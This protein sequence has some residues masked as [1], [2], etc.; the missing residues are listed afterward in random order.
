[1]PC[2]L[3]D[4]KESEKLYDMFIEE[5]GKNREELKAS[6]LKIY[7]GEYVYCGSKIGIEKDKIILYLTLKMPKQE[8]KLYDDVA[9]GVDIGMAMPAY[10][11]INTYGK[12]Y[13]RKAIG[14]IDDFL[15]MKTKISN[16]RRRI[17]TNDKKNQGG[18]GR[19]KKLK[20]FE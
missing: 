12:E 14:D 3:R 4:S 18:H 15:T 1:M 19:K 11:S 7:S 16:Q 6:L 20:S 10:V 9:V 2:V 17:Q 5:L 13:I 8:C